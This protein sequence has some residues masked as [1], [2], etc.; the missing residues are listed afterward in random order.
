MVPGYAPIP[1]PM[2]GLLLKAAHIIVEGC[3]RG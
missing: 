2:R 3:V 1:E